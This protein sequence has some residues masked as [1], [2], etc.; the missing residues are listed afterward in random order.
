M[1]R[2][3]SDRQFFREFEPEEVV[4]ADGEGCTSGVWSNQRQPF[5]GP[6]GWQLPVADH[7]L[8]IHLVRVEYHVDARPVLG[9]N[10][11]LKQV[12]VWVR[13]VN[14]RRP[15]V[16][17]ATFGGAP[18]QDARHKHPSEL[19]RARGTWNR[20]LRFK[21]RSQ[22]GTCT[23]R[24][25]EIQSVCTN[26]IVAAAAAAG[27]CVCVCVCVCVRVCTC[28]YVCVYVCVWC[29]DLEKTHK[30]LRP[31]DVRVCWLFGYVCAR[32]EAACV[33]APV[34][35]MILVSCGR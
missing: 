30:A 12:R 17:F 34:T 26:S 4:S 33:C 8:R 6:G 25:K 9:V 22:I 24:L 31:C 21:F 11:R 10:A 27:V 15:N 14:V 23:T 32:D 35:R 19:T 20:K 29:Q 5:F 28:V 2:V 1:D 7:E 18:R 3:A 13:G 16:R